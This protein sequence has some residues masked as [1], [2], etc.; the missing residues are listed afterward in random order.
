MDYYH[1]E[2]YREHLEEVV[3]NQPPGHICRRVQRQV[4]RG[5]AFAEFDVYLSS[6]AEVPRAFDMAPPE[7]KRRSAKV[8]RQHV[9]EHLGGVTFGMTLD[10]IA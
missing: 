10:L 1:F 7:A 8:L 3:I 6:A 9:D 2:Q 5:L 4:H